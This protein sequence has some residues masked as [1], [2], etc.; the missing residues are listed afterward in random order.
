LQVLLTHRSVQHR[1]RA[2]VAL[3][4]LA[5]VALVLAACG[6]SGGGGDSGASSSD[7][8]TLLRE[9]FSGSHTIRSGKA[10]VQ[11]R[12][13]VTGEPSL[14]GP[15]ELTISGPFESAGTD[16]VPKFDL[17]LDAHVQGQGFQAGL[18]STSDQLFV[19]FGGTSYAVPAQLMDQLRASYRRSQQQGSSRQSMSLQSLGIDPARWLKDPKVVGSDTVGGA[20]TDH[21]SGDVDTGALLDDVDTLLARVKDQGLAGTAGQRIPSRLS[22][23]DRAQIEQ[24]VKQATVDVWSGKD[25]HT[26]R[27]LTLAL[28]VVPPSGSGGPR[29]VDLTISIELT[30]LNKPQTISAPATSRPLSELLGQFQGLLGGALGGSALGG[31]AGAPGSAGGASSQQLNAYSQCI[32]RAGSNVT[33]AQKCADLLTK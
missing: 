8:Q 3:L 28:N 23:S 24:A 13:V 19:K 4:A 21:I 33:E 29:S 1:A 30:D 14:R 2:V 15:I 11:L 20:D 32:E 7:A 12:A 10:N 6:S 27:R 25:D 26:L 9:T 16:Q 18:A 17:A 31:G 5:V 22:A